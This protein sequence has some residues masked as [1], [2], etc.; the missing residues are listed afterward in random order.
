MKL[1]NAKM[2]KWIIKASAITLDIEE[3]DTLLF[4]RYK[5]SPH[6]VKEIGTDE[7]GQPTVNGMKLL[8]C[9]IKKNMDKKAAPSLDLS[10]YDEMY[11]TFD[12]GHNADHQKQV[13]D[14][15]RR[16]AITHA[17]KKLDLT[18]L[19]A[20]L[21]DIGL[22]KGRDSHEHHGADMIASDT[23]FNTLAPVDRRVL[24]NA[25]RHHRASTGKPSSVVGKIVSDADRAATGNVADA[26]ARAVQ[27]Q[28]K[29]N[30]ELDD[31]A[32]MRE[33]LAHL[34]TKYAPGSYGRRT[35]FP[36]T[37]EHLDRVFAPLF[38]KKAQAADLA[39]IL[40]GE[41]G[42]GEEELYDTLKLKGINPDVTRSAFEITEDYIKQ[43]LSKWRKLKLLPSI[44]KAKLFGKQ[45]EFVP[46]FLDTLEREPEYNLDIGSFTNRYKDMGPDFTNRI[47][48]VA[49]RLLQDI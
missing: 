14:F 16:L 22:A 12:G 6:V 9:R 40:R 27:Y 46:R 11:N 2:A 23:R 10:D 24:I 45:P 35:H 44:I 41:Q 18:D 32:R 7:K 33:A 5:N 21:H 13:R 20:R 15:A 17:P 19:A 36:E 42:L 1:N 38:A 37:A 30:S 47:K 48:R 25:I 3:G 39:S 28:A 4:G 8:A 43:N 31:T 29:N 26:I 34:R 49:S